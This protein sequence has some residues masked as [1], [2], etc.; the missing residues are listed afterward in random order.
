MKRYILCCLSVIILSANCHGLFITNL[1]QAPKTHH[2]FE[3]N[4]KDNYTGRK[5]NYEGREITQS[6]LSP[7]HGEGSKYKNEDPNLK[8]ENNPDQIVFSSNI[9]RYIF[10]FALVVA[11]IYLLYVL[12]NEG[13]SGLFSS[14]GNQKLNDYGE[15]TADTIEN[16]DVQA[17][18][19][20]AERDS[21]F[22]LA[23]RYYYLLVLKTLS[24]KKFITFED[25]KTNAEYLNETA[26][27]GF[28]NNFAYTSYLYN[29]IW[30][31]EF[32]LN[33]D[34]YR[35]AKQRFKSLL[36]EVK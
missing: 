33:S 25:D 28:S 3:N 24:I 29:Y 1:V 36:T 31:G 27:L 14:K 7:V 22:R 18:I 19:D 23:I 15:I 8:E 4:F 21:D 12:F 34:Q 6:N 10:I 9:I 5:Y 16:A 20:R 32:P 35:V 2:E 26:H 13:S 17:L 30:Y 11:V